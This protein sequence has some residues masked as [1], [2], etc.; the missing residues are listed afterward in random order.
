MYK[1]EFFAQDMAFEAAYLLQ[2]DTALLS[3]DHLTMDSFDVDLPTEK[4]PVSK[5]HFCRR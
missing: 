5:G 4:T 1:A 3:E 2:E